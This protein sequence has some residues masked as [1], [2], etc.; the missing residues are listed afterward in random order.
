MTVH[1]CKSG[2][3]GRME[4]VC[5][6]IFYGGSFGKSSGE[7]N[8]FAAEGVGCMLYFVGYVQV[9]LIDTDCR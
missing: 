7:L 3:C 2:G 9:G 8:C 1:G 4:R 5:N 6:R